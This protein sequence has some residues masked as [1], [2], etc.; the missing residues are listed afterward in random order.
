MI[1]RV[2]DLGHEWLGRWVVGVGGWGLML[3]CCCCQV[4]IHPGPGGGGAVHSCGG[5]G[6]PML[7]SYYCYCGLLA[8][9]WCPPAKLQQG[10]DVTPSH[11]R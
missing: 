11:T 6:D 10:E 2:R 7:Q 1:G 5:E 4:L 3:G 8:L 9:G